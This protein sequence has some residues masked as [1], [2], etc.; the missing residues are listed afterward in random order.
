MNFAQVVRVSWFAVALSP[1]LACSFAPLSP[2]SGDEVFIGGVSEAS[3]K[4]RCD[5][6]L[7]YGEAACERAERCG[8]QWWV[9]GWDRTKCAHQTASMVQAFSGLDFYG[10]GSS[11]QTVR[12]C[13][14]KLK[15][16]T[17]APV[18]DC[19]LFSQWSSKKREAGIECSSRSDCKVGLTCADDICAPLRDDGGECRDSEDCV[20]GLSC[21]KRVCRPV[22]EGETK[23][24]QDEDCSNERSEQGYALFSFWSFGG[25]LYCDESTLKCRQVTRSAQEKEPC[26]RGHL[27][28]DGLHCRGLLGAVGT[29]TCERAAAYG[30]ACDA[31]SCVSC[32]SDGVCIDPLESI[33]R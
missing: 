33:C 14:Q 9:W 31:T 22:V 26:A 6:A 5:A 32:S 20:S 8:R 13:A 16:E 10:S 12:D 2:L 4:E 17:C 24:Y 30:E 27:C 25:H 3:Q 11:V 28:A 18:T 15:T 29:P 7:E 23:C 19:A 1:A 21:Q